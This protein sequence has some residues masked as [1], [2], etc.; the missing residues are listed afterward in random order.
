MGTVNVVERKPLTAALAS[1]VVRGGS[2]HYADRLISGLEKTEFIEK[3]KA[4]P[5]ELDRSFGRDENSLSG[6]LVTMS[7]WR[8][9][10]PVRT[11]C[12]VVLLW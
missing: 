8:S 3:V 1:G 9:L 7:R 5:G 10:P 6:T 2:T 4:C 12:G 11:R